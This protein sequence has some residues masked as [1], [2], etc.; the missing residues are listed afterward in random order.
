MVL[1]IN[2][3]VNMKINRKDIFAN[4]RLKLTFYYTL[5][6]FI[7]LLIFSETLIFTVESKIHENFNGKIIVIEDN[8]KILK[9]TSDE[10]EILIYG[11]DG[12]LLI[13]IAFLSYFLAGKTLK[14]IKE[15][16]ELQKRFLADASHDLRTPIAIMMTDTEVTL[17]NNNSNKQEFQKLAI[18]NLEEIRNMEK[19]VNNLLLLARTEKNIQEVSN[20][21]FTDFLNLLVNKMQSQIDTKHLKLFKNIQEN[22]FINTDKENLEIAIKNVL[23]NAINYTKAGEIKV[24]L[25]KENTKI[26][27]EIIDTG[28][29]I[30]EKDLPFVFDR[31]YKAE[32]SRNDGSGSGLGLSIAKA[33]IEK[34]NG[35]IKIES[36][37]DIGTK[38]V[39]MLKA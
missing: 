26:V 30:K 14:P 23:Q 8:D 4:A 16:L 9:K 32:H 12:V 20:T 17:Q 27:L 3:M 1:D 15:N 24:S 29:G 11:I 22:I 38:V 33:I 34:N 13:L 10:I 7:I 31:F 21:S 35:Q 39:I 36:R 5:I 6:I 2:L 18:S 28:V 37:E 25:R 19:I